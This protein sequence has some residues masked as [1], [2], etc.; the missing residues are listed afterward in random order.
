MREG[1]GR[2]RGRGILLWLRWRRGLRLLGIL[3][4]KDGR[5]G[6]RIGRLGY[7]RRGLILDYLGNR[8]IP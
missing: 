5:L 3:S 2:G 7:N 8:P 6:Q 1:E 4:S